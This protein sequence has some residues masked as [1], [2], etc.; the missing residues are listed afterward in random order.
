[1]EKQAH[2]EQENS[3]LLSQKAIGF[4]YQASQWSRFI[5]IV[6]FVSIGFIVLGGLF[7][8]IVVSVISDNLASLPFPPFLISFIY[9][10]IALIFFFPVYY[11]YSFSSKAHAAIST[12]N[13]VNMDE[14]FKN[15]K[16]HYKFIGVFF[17]ITL[18]L[19]II[20]IIITFTMGSMFMQS[21]MQ[22]TN[23]L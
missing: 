16:S 8:G 17:I 3:I 9:L 19:N 21:L 20:G 7:T 11:L 15:L 18:C 13:G 1:M 4:I 2:H 14:A 5:A 23:H 6:G 12:H 10:F 22:H